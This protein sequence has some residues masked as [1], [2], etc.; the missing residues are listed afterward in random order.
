[1]D[2]CS[3]EIST[4]NSM[5]SVSKAVG[6]REV[7]SSGVQNSIMCMLEDKHG[8]EFFNKKKAPRFTKTK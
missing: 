1:M 6:F 7:K 3:A 2:H 8:E 4:P 5:L